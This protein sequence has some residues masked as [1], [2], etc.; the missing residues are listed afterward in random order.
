MKGKAREQQGIF[1]KMGTG[2]FWFTPDCPL[3]RGSMG[4]AHVPSSGIPPG[5]RWEGGGA[6]LGQD[7]ASTKIEAPPDHPALLPEKGDQQECDSLSD[8]PGSVTS[9]KKSV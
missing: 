5:R 6:A 4:Q 8:S 9:S 1:L 2:H 3:H 7:E